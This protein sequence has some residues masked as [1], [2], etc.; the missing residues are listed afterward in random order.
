V[1]SHGSV[2]SRPSPPSPPSPGPSAERRVAHDRRAHGTPHFEVCRPRQA[3]RHHFGPRGKT[4]CS[5]DVIG[6]S[7]RL[8]TPACHDRS[9]SRGD[10]SIES[11]ENSQSRQRPPAGDAAPC[12]RPSRSPQAQVAVGGRAEGRRAC[13]QLSG[14]SRRVS[15]FPRACRAAGA[16]DSDVSRPSEIHR[17]TGESG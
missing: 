1:S 3:P 13:R 6:S 11:S 17:E 10:E 5:I 8:S 16:N 2:S 12:V 15:A 4:R 14:R 7:N 9:A